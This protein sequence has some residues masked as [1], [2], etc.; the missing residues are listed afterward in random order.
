MNKLELDRAFNVYA[1]EMQRLDD[2]VTRVAAPGQ[3]VS[4]LVVQMD[5]LVVAVNC[6]NVLLFELIRLAQEAEAAGE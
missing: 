2:Q 5:R 1:Q 6:T 4:V 3:G